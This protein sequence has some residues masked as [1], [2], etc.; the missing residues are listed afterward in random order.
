[1]NIKT[2]RMV[3]WTAQYHFASLLQWRGPNRVFILSA[4]F[5]YSLNHEQLL[6][7][8]FGIISNVVPIQPDEDWSISL[9]ENRSLV[10]MTSNPEKLTL[11]FEK[12]PDFL[13]KKIRRELCSTPFSVITK[14]S[15]VSPSR[16]TSK[17]FS[18]SPGT[19]WGRGIAALEREERDVGGSSFTS[20][21]WQEG[22]L[23]K[24]VILWTILEILSGIGM[25]HLKFFFSKNGIWNS[26]F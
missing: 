3:V 22:Y 14:M 21:F 15:W 1:M 23:I 16:T 2:N 6:T 7:P 9:L 25:M 11:R 12:A 20:S 8:G 10:V 18:Q 24:L 19:S 13:V 4:D 5:V 17:D 26:L